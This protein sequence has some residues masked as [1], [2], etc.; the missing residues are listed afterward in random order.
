MIR[1]TLLVLIS[2]VIGACA[3]VNI[4]ADQFVSRTSVA[5]LAQ[6]SDVILVATVTGE[7]GTRNMARRPDNPIEPHQTLFSLGQDYRLGVEDVLKGSASPIVIVSISKAA[8]TEQG[9]AQYKE[10]IPLTVGQ[11]Y[12]LFLRN[13][14]DGTRDFVP[15][16]EPWRFRLGELATAESPWPDAGRHFPTA[17][18]MQI[19]A[20]VRAALR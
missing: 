14:I 18:A 10:F 5:A 19:L 3:E 7:A 17:P 8:K 13:Q 1:I 12:L 6:A 2:L 4:E 16:P 15:A 20:Q 11:R 9:F